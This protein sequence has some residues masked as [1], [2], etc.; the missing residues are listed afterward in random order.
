M[1]GVADA[2]TREV[3]RL[4]LPGARGVRPVRP[5]DAV[6]DEHGACVGWVLS[7]ATVK[8]TQ[9]ALSYVDLVAAQQGGKLG[10]YYLARSQSQAEQGRKHAVEKGESLQAA[11]AGGGV[12]RFGQF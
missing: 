6:L 10:V 8:E 4:E 1:Q 7:S 2:R 3:A 11:L 9:Y 5:D 12:S